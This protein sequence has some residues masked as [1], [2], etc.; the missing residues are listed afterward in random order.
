MTLLPGR[1]AERGHGK[2]AQVDPIKPTVKAPETKP[3]NLKY[4][5]MLSIFLQFCF[6]F[7]RAALHH[8]QEPLSQR[9]PKRVPIGVRHLV[10]Q[11]RLTL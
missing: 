5:P 1:A 2:A 7:E 4:N 8:G 11:C 10:G 3:L 6:Q 9:V